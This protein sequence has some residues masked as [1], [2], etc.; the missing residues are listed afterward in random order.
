MDD[1]EMAGYVLTALKDNR[2]PSLGACECFLT[3]QEELG[4]CHQVKDLEMGGG[5]LSWT[6]GWTQ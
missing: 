3:G 4:R 5:G 6:T 1:V 2:S